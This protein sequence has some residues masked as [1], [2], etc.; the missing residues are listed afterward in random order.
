MVQSELDN[1]CVNVIRGLAIDAVEKAKS[2][3][4]GMPMGCAPMAHALWS[5]HLK[6]NPKNP[7]WFD[8]DRFILSAGHGSMLIYSLLHLTGYDVTMEDI[9]QF[10]QWGSR[11]P[12]HPENTHTPGVEMATGP[13]GQGISTSIG[14]AIAESF[15]AARY[16]R[17]GHNII[18][19]FTYVICSDGDLMEGVAQEACSLA[20]HL[21]LGKLICLYDD[22][23]ITIDGNTSLSFTEDT[24][25]KFEAMNWQVLH[26]DGLDIDQVSNAI[27]SA[28]SEASKPTLIVAKTIIGFG[29]PNKANSEKSHGSPLGAEEVVLTKRALGLPEDKTF[30]IPKEVSEQMLG[31]VETGVAA[32]T[33]WTEA[34]KAYSASFPAE[35]AELSKLISGEASLESLL[36]TPEFDKP[37]ATRGANGVAVAAVGNDFAGLIGGSADLTNNVMTEIKGGGW[38]SPQNRAGR[39]IAFGIREHAMAAAANGITLH[40]GTR[41]MAGTF[42]VFS[43]YCRPS[44]RLAALMHIPTIFCFSHDSIGLGEDGPTHQPVEHLAACRAIPN[45]NVFRPADANETMVAWA[46]AATAKDFPSLVVT[47]RQN[48]EIHSPKFAMDH[49]AFKGGYVLKSAENPKLIIVATGSEVMLAMQAASSL[50]A[51]GIATRVVSLPSWFLFERQSDSYKSSV[52][53]KSI[54]TLSLEAGTTMGWAKY[55]SAHVGL[56]RFGA[57]APGPVAMDKLGFNVENVV[58]EAKKLL[59]SN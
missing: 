5:R 37:V 17:P 57:S 36:A 6:H 8:R 23:S 56:D 20:G 49:P 24:T 50:E 21:G 54:P 59:S 12:G 55:A 16:N 51:E 11:T 38:Y 48:L 44:V 39:N 15:L 47:S 26:V 29:S 58:A 40:G 14:F 34:M 1:L 53:P 4:P 18:D 35:H 13:L 31:A 41:G 22:N 46:I 3:H 43:D 33:A 45:C 7:K 10:R 19:H 9:H 27:D 25:K 52:L 30:W 32:E 42:F 2:G 28:K